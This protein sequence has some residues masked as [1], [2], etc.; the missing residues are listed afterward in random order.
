MRTKQAKPPALETGFAA[1]CWQLSLENGRE[2]ARFNGTTVPTR[3]C[4]FMRGFQSSP[5]PDRFLMDF[6]TTVLVAENS[7]IAQADRA[8][9][10]PADCVNCSEAQYCLTNAAGEIPPLVAQLKQLVERTGLRDG[11]GSLRVAAALD[12]ALQNAIIHGNLEVSSKLRECEDA[13]VYGNMIRLRRQEAPFKDR[14]AFVRVRVT[15]DSA[16]FSIRDEGPGFNPKAI[17]NPTDPANLDRLC[18]RGLWL[19]HAFMDE[20]KYNDQGN[21]ITMIVHKRAM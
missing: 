1:A 10:L 18:G 7:P 16:Q 4:M 8:N 11:N 17:P 5:T 3:Y 20:V 14:R 6:Q 21:E 2:W 15:T 12:E 19:I 13:N 9:S